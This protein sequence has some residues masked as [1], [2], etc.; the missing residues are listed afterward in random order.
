MPGFVGEII[1]VDN[2]VSNILG[3]IVG[4]RRLN[5]PKPRL[6]RMAMAFVLNSFCMI[7]SFIQLDPPSILVRKV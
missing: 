5:F 1:T 3:V 7:Q 2:T 6:E 4:T